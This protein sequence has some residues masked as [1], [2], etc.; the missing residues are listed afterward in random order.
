[1]IFN[2]KLTLEQ[3]LAE[4]D[5]VAADIPG[6]APAGADFRSTSEGRERISEIEGLYKN[7]L[8]VERK[9]EEYML[10]PDSNLSVPP[11]PKWNEFIEESLTFIE[12]SSKD[13]L[14]ATLVLEAAAR[15]Y[16]IRGLRLSLQLITK[17]VEKWPNVYP[18]TIQPSPDGRTRRFSAW[19]YAYDWNARLYPKLNRILRVTSSG[20]TFADIAEAR[21]LDDPKMNPEQRQQRMSKGA[22]TLDSIRSEIKQK[23]VYFQDNYSDIKACL[24][25][26]KEL[27][28]TTQ[29]KCKA[30]DD[31]P[32]Q[33]LTPDFSELS[34][35][36]TLLVS[37]MKSIA[38]PGLLL[39]EA[40]KTEAEGADGEGAS[41]EGSGRSGSGG[42]PGQLTRELAFA[43]LQEL[44]N[45]FRQSEPHSPISYAI[46]QAVRWG[47]LSLPELLTE[48]IADTNSRKNLFERTGVPE[49][50]E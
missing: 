34:N 29:A 19:R 44:A 17:L 48:L 36:L 43:R 47:Q 30:T 10:L 39:D 8:N 24:E 2:A 35:Q 4:V 21:Q 12:S 25:L 9:Y 22:K 3:Q 20:S 31:L 27:T 45:F 14:L 26:I 15:E 5:K 33:A 13:L 11:P 40:P 6:D 50:K 18:S 41:G 1:M 28:A 37:T 38:W 49:P 32:E 42:A 7:A 23:E 46:E 16:G